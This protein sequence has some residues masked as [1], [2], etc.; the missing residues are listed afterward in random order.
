M[1]HAAAT[2]L[3]AELYDELRRFCSHERIFVAF[4]FDGTLSEIVERPQDARPVDGAVEGLERLAASHGVTVSLISGRGMKE[5]AELSGS[6]RGVHLIGGHGAQFSDALPLESPAAHVDETLR[7]RVLEELDTIAAADA[8]LE[9]EPKATGVAL[10]YRRAP[11]DAGRV[12]ERQARE[13]VGRLDG[14]VIKAGKCVIEFSLVDTNKGEAIDR[15]RVALGV[16]AT[17]FAGDDVT[18]EEGFA[19]LGQNDLSIKVGDGPT[20]ARHRLP[21]PRHVVALM[22]AIAELRS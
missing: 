5:L 10:H 15:L 12:A 18:D 20:R 16:G 1:T 4:D 17:L 21:S 22:S 7:T 6:P 9:V 19:A 11:E 13:R 2:G 3:G 14:V 8:G